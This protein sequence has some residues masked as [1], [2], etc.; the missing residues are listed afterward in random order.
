MKSV[1]RKAREDALQILYQLD[2]NNDLSV[3]L[4]LNYFQSLYSKN[5]M[6]LDPFTRRLVMGVGEKANDIDHKIKE[7]SSNWRPDRMAAVDRNILRLGAFELLFCDDIPATVTLNEM[8]ELAKEFGAENT[9]AF[10]NGVLDQLKT[11]FPVTGK[12]E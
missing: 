8:V 10:V 11:K 6:A 5:Q 4:A 3:E 2:L 9:P 1:R 7:I 12:T